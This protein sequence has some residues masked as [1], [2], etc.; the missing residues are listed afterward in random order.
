MIRQYICLKWCEK[1]DVDISL[2][3]E[4]VGINDRSGDQGAGPD[5]EGGEC[6]GVLP[7][8]DRQGGRELLCG[9]CAAEWGE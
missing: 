3:I 8:G 4:V 1:H 9:G 6:A 2:Y 5:D 7:D